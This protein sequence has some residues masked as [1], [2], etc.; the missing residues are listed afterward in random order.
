MDQ[1][2][3]E[4]LLLHGLVRDS[5]GRK[6]SKSLGNGINPI[7]VID[8]YGSDVLRMSLIFNCTPGLDINYSDEKIQGAK[9]FANKF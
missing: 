9:L 8:E 1:K 3:F 7:Q 2:P 4:H 5:Q 6:M